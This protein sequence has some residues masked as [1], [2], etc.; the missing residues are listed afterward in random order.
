MYSPKI[1]SRLVRE[2]YQLKQLTKQPMTQLVNEAVVEYLR[3]T[4]NEKTKAGLCKN[5]SKDS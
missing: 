3:R 2:L 5:G 1:E 4:K